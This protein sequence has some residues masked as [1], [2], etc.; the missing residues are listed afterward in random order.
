MEIDY[1]TGESWLEGESRPEAP[2][3]AYVLNT[4]LHPDGTTLRNSRKR[5]L[6]FYD[7]KDILDPVR[8]DFGVDWAFWR[9]SRPSRW[10]LRRMWPQVWLP[11]VQPVRLSSSM[12]GFTASRSAWRLPA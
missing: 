3:T 7:A 6:Q 12:M 2:E 5:Y 9:A 8:P 4:S 11:K 10:P 1:A